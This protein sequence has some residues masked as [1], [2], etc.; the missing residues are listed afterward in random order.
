VALGSANG[1]LSY[2]WAVVRIPWLPQPLLSLVEREIALDRLVEDLNFGCKWVRFFC[3]ATQ[4][5]RCI[6]CTT[7]RMTGL[8]PS[9]WRISVGTTRS[10]LKPTQ[11]NSPARAPNT[12]EFIA[13]IEQNGEDRARTA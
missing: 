13:F 8:W 9:G 6:R 10:C 5:L 1:G 2:I 12:D 7:H 11:R 4:E 3:S